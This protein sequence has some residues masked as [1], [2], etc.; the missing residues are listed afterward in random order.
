[1]LLEEFKVSLFEKA[2]LHGFSQYEIYYLKEDVLNVETFQG[3]LEKYSVSE[4]QGLSFRGIFNEKMGYSYTEVLDEVSVDFLINS[5]KENAVV[6]EN[7]EKEIIYGEKE[8]YSAFD[9]YEE[10]ISK[11][12]P[13]EKIKLALDMEVAAKKE[14]DRV[15]RVQSVVEEVDSSYHIINSKGLDLSFRSNAIF[16]VVEPVV[17]DKE[18][19][20]SAYSFICTRNF[21]KINPSVLAKE[22][23]EKSLAFTGAESVK[24]GNYHIAML[25]EAAA[26]LLST[27]SGI[28]SA[29]NVQKGLSLLKDKVGERISS[30]RVTII[31]NPL[32]KEGMKSKPFDDEGVATYTKE[33]ISEGKLKTLLYNLKTATKAGVK[34]TGNGAKDTYSSPVEVAPSNFYFKP[35]HKDFDSILKA[36]GDGILITELQGLHSG[37]NPVSGDFSLAAKGFVIKDGII[38]RA[39]EQ[40][41]IAGNFYKLLE[42]IEEVGA[43]L[44]F[45]FPSGKGYFGSPTLIIKVMS[46]AGN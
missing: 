46:I 11:I 36:L 22:A 28:F 38:N 31:D 1:M 44:K 20:N 15:I 17:S 12:T 25:N 4:T 7:E 26:S 2:E 40:I 18:R 13:I 19:M 8:K 23:V 29:D 3:E 45:G 5:A 37:A 27:F 9:G 39:V 35:G 43:D 16:A 24:S 6:I 41:T 42:D 14:S 32:L 34:S 30:D 21:D 33:V 10:K